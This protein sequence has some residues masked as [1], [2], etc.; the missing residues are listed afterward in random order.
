MPRSFRPMAARILAAPWIV[1]AR[2]MRALCSFGAVTYGLA[3]VEQRRES[4]YR[5]VLNGVSCCSLDSHGDGLTRWK[6][7]PPYQVNFALGISHISDEK[8]R[9]W[10]RY[11]E[12]V[13]RGSKN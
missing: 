1:K 6:G 13:H 12:L 11:R 5:N 10:Q 7:F 8:G 4:C 9:W 3:G 2:G